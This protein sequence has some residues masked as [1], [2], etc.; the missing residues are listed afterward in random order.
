M[1]RLFAFDSAKTRIPKFFRRKGK[2][3]AQTGFETG[4][5]LSTLRNAPKYTGKYM[6]VHESESILGQS[7]ANATPLFWVT[8]D[9]SDEALLEL[10]N[11]L[12]TS[13][14]GFTNLAD[15]VAWASSNDFMIISASDNIPGGNLVMHLDV[16]KVEC[17]PGTGN[18][19]YDLSGNNNHATLYNT[20][21]ISGGFITWNGTNEYAQMSYNSNMAGWSSAQ[22]VVMWLRHSFTSGRRNPWDQAYG[23]YGTWT[24]E[25]GNNINNYF[26]DSGSNTT[27]YTSGNSGTTNR[28]Q[29]NLLVT[30]RNTSQQKWYVNGNNTSTRGHSY[31]TLTATT[32]V[33]R[34]ARGYA[35]YWQGHMGP[36]I[37]Y[38]RVLS[39]D[40]VKSIYYGGPIVTSELVLAVDSGV[41]GSFDQGETIT[42]DLTGGTQGELFNG[43]GYSSTQKTWMF[44]GTNDYIEFPSDIMNDGEEYTLSI[45]LRPNGS[46]WGNNAIPMYNTYAGNSSYGFWHHFGHD[47]V[48]RWRHGG[49]TYTI[50]D[51]PGIGLVANEW[52][53]TTVTFDNT[54]L[55]LYKN[56]TYSNHTTAAR[57]F[58]RSGAGA[59]IGM[60][61]YR[62]TSNDYNWNGDIACQHVYNRALTADEVMQNFNAQ[63]ARFGL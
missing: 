28:N 44:D 59:R 12:P 54:T 29:W 39:A 1:G 9:D 53:L 18:I 49:S 52:Q 38:D 27:P 17:W 14:D 50:G 33:V 45:W 2:V 24:H 55:R 10:I 34:L 3:S 60:L 15:A 43:V 40:E 6:I 32:R 62:R 22:S 16:R 61:N 47:N 21:V 25:Q 58:R 63:R 8:N 4:S 23:G 37:A 42:Y 11:R 5:T 26:G 48:L 41:L 30:T 31:S 13:P 7:A 20:P 56:G 57:A 51:L 36:V 35:G 46:S 19:L